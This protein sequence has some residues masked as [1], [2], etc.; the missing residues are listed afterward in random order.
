VIY[1]GFSPSR[2]DIRKI[3]D[4]NYVA[5]SN[6]LRHYLNCFVK[7]NPNRSKIYLLHK[8]QEPK[9][10]KAFLNE[11]GSD[12]IAPASQ[13]D[14]TKLQPAMDAARVVKS[15][16]EL[17]AIRHACAITAEAHINVLARL[18]TFE[19]ESEIEAWFSGTCIALQAKN[20]AY[21][22]IAGSG[23]NASTLH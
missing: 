12:A 21:D 20:Q 4:V 16:Y 5:E 11:D 17:Q 7:N 13:F 23:E 9:L 22:I 1:N 6:W 14:F 19:N 15:P 8:A 3:A 2:A 10:P 18:K